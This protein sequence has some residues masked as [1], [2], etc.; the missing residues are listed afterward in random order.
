MY[1]Q[2]TEIIESIQSY[3]VQVAQLYFEIYE[4]LDDGDMKNLIY[5]LYEHE[6][7]R[8]NYL[9]RHLI[10]A[11]AMN[12]YLI[13]PCEKLQNQISS[14]FVNLNYNSSLSMGELINIQLHFDACLIKMYNIL[15]AENALNG[16]MANIFY[17]MLKKT[18]KEEALLTQLFI[19]SK[20]N[21]DFDFRAL[22]TI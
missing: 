15:S 1:K 4:K 9:D 17:Y 14:C 16:E 7:Y 5:E 20:S 21:I 19:Q 3:H 22:R 12:S 2:K 18:K 6:I 8:K 10:I 13:F 11:K